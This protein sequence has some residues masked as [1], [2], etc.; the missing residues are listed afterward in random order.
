M[1]R[2][3]EVTLEKRTVQLQLTATAPTAS[4]PHCA[5]PSS[6][7]HSRY[8]RH[9]TDLPWGTRAVHLQLIV[10]KF[11]CRQPTCARPIFT[12]RLPDFVAPSA[13]KTTRLIAILR[14]IGVALRGQAGAR[15]AARLW[16]STSAATLLRLVR[17]ALVPPTPDL[18]AVGVDEWAWRRGRRF[19]TILVDLV[20]H[21]VLDLLPE[22]SA[23]AVPLAPPRPEMST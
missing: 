18:Q 9:L 15:L 17:A 12:E 23:A 10:R 3:T 2:L 4:G 6:A 7:V 13:R 22:R 20:S 19:G 8:Q 11:V 14:A 16:L 5:V 1:M 21:R